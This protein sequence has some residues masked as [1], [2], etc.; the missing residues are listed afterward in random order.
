MQGCKWAA[1]TIVVVAAPMLGKVTQ[2]SVERT[3]GT[4]FGGLLG[5]A[6]VLLG[7]GFGQDEDI[8][9]T[10]FVAFLVG[11]GAVCVGWVLSLDYSAKLFVMTFVLV[12]MGS[13]EPSDASLV[14]LTRI[15]GIVGGV[16]LMLMLSAAD[17]MAEAMIDL[18]NLSKLAWKATNGDT[19]QQTT[20]QRMERARSLRQPDGYMLLQQ[21]DEESARKEAAANRDAAEVD[22]EKMLMQVYDKLVKCDELL[23]V[24]A[25]EVY[26]K[27]FRGRWCFLPALPWLR[28]SC[29]G[30]PGSWRIPQRE[31]HDL[32]TC[33]RRVARVLWALHVTFQE[34]FEGEVAVVLRRHFPT[35]LLA[36]LQASSQGALVELAQAFP[37]Q[38]A[39]ES[40]GLS[41]FTQVVLDLIRISEE[42]RNAAVQQLTRRRGTSRRASS[43]KLSRHAH[44]F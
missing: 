13:N 41:R 37:Y 2:V 44:Y 31:M 4:I 32:A 39:S 16:M 23:P 14:A 18:V 38:P 19:E 35:S 22:C 6:T 7:H 28:M 36:D 25:N 11:F 34:G 42:Q 40:I 27:T 21:E 26:F 10:G 29:L 33:M 8:A 5:L 17:N 12:V 3:I 30:S 1:I 24:A 15:V 43:E 20:K 9:I